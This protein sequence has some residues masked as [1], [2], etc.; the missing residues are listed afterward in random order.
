[1]PVVALAP[2][3]SFIRKDDIF[4]PGSFRARRKAYNNFQYAYQGR[5]FGAL[6][7]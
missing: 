5:G 4:L 6:Q 2:K 1:M 3:G 7:Q